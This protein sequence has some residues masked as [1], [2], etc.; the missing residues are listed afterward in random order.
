MGREEGGLAAFVSGSDRAA[1]VRHGESVK[2]GKEK[3]D[4]V[5]ELPGRRAD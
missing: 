1:V 4:E 5:S 3:R 2:G